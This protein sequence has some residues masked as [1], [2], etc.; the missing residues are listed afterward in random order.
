MGD[1]IQPLWEN[2]ALPSA[3]SANSPIQWPH[4]LFLQRRFDAILVPSSCT[5][6][7]FSL[8][9]HSTVHTH[10]LRIFGFGIGT[11]KFFLILS[12]CVHP[13]HPVSHNIPRSPSEVGGRGRGRDGGRDG[14]DGPSTDRPTDRPNGAVIYVTRF[15]DI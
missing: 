15:V 8:P 14:R 9:P 12:S 2:H 11:E 3:A 7:N 10:V 13:S 1:L 5:F 4:I 6:I